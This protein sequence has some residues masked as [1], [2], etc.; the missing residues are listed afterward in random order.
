MPEWAGDKRSG[1]I[2]GHGQSLLNDLEIILQLTDKCLRI[3]SGSSQ[4]T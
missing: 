3:P 4:G 1:T 2:R